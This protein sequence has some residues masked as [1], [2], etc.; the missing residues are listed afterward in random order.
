MMAKQRHT[1]ASQS[2][3]HKKKASEALTSLKTSTQGLSDKDAATRL[4]RFG[5]NSITTKTQSWLKRIVE[6]F[7]S[8]FVIILLVALI[9]SILMQEQFDAII[10]GIVVIINA[11]IYYFQ[12]ISVNRVLKTLKS[13]SGSSITVIRSG[14]TKEVSSK[15]IVPGDIVFVFEGLKIPAD[16]RLIEVSNLQVDESV[17]TGESLP[18]NK[19]TDSLPEKTQIY[20]QDNMVFKGTIV[21][22]GSGQIVV[23]STGNKT[24]LG[25][26]TTLTSL[27]DVG[28]TPIE[29][30]ID[31]ITKKFIYGI[32]VATVL[33]FVLAIVRGISTAEALRFTLS[34]VVSVVP[35]NLPVT[36]T[37]VLMLSAKRMARHKVLIKKLSAIETMGAVTL[38]ATD[39]TGTITA[40]RLEVADIYPSDSRVNTAAQ[41]SIVLQNG[42]ELDPLDQILSNHFG[43]TKLAGKLI[44]SFP[45]DQ[46]LRMSGSLWKIEGHLILFVK[47]APESIFLH[48]HSK[49]NKTISTQLA[50]FTNKGYRT[51]AFAHKKISKEIQALSELP[52]KSLTFDGIVALT[53]PIRKNIPKSINDAHL[54]GIN[55]IMLTGDHKNTAAEIGRQAGLVTDIHQ[56][57]DSKLLEKS[58]NKK[59]IQTL[60][61]RIKVFGRVL[62]KHKFNFLKAVKGSEITAMTGDGVNDIPAL[63]EADV[64]LA[65]GSGT[66]AAKDASDIVLLDDNFETI[67][68]AVRLGRSVVANIRKMLFYLISTSIGEAGTMIGALVLGLPLPVT[69]VQILWINIVTDTFTVLPIGLAKPEKYQMKSPPKNPKSPILS[70]VLL[71]RTVLAGLLM[72]GVTVFIFWLLLP[73]GYAYAQTAA[74]TTLVVAQWANAL[75]ANF[76]RHSW[77]RNFTRPNFKLFAGIGIS[78]ILQALVIFGPLQ[79]AFGV[80]QLSGSDLAL[81]LILPTV[82]VLLA[83]DIHK[84]LFKEEY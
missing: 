22:S 57:A 29:K 28:K 45:F 73:K 64:G 66:D 41:G 78:M 37:V 70:N 50:E 13:H 74:F 56:I 60:L 2:S 67:I 43:Q 83:V 17:L 38:I 81:T 21:Q 33:V 63:V 52:K 79:E 8:L 51:I 58:P 32:G 6:P 61:S 68:T 82:I 44:R 54:A 84:L 18:Q 14:K 4:E 53:D 59:I 77:L 49:T 23:T 26:I 39:K 20:D 3:W 40:N 25:A 34:L 69:A 48:T 16:G 35:E 36:L 7:T 75:N 72:A 12:Q 42:I 76:D 10:I 46:D 65:M 19:S 5:P 55:V 31:D 47:G 24:Q 1:K 15:D 11:L 30:K 27:G 71:S 80:E 62:P 9:I